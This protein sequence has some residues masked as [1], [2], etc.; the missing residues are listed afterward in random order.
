M[1]WFNRNR[2]AE[3]GLAAE[4]ERVLAA[5]AHDRQQAALL[6]WATYDQMTNNIQIAGMHATYDMASD[7]PRLPYVAGYLDR[8]NRVNDHQAFMHS[9]GETVPNLMPVTSHEQPLGTI[10]LIG[11]LSSATD[12]HTMEYG[13]G[14][15]QDMGSF[16]PNRTYDPQ[17]SEHAAAAREV[18]N[19]AMIDLMPRDEPPAAGRSFPQAA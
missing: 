1:T 16:D 6:K 4:A 2:K 14:P 12:S 3:R 11:L 19:L 10:A 9:A 13:L 15:N 7:D 8:L 5:A 18:V 17:V